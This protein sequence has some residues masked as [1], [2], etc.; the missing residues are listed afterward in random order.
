MMELTWAQIRNPGFQQA[1]AKLMNADLPFKTAYH[2]GRIGDRVRTE[3]NS[4][5]EWFVKLVKKYADVNEADGTFKVKDEN[6]DKWLEEI[7]TFEATKFNVEKSK[8]L[9]AQLES[10]RL[11]PNEIIALEPILAGLEVLEGGK[12]N[13]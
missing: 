11:T 2:V 13:G 7:K 4:S 8:V 3:M 5:Q 9:I 1:I 10:V 6:L 12:Q